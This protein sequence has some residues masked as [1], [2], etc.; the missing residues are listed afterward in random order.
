MF[1]WRSWWRLNTKYVWI[2]LMAW[3]SRW[4]GIEAQEKLLSATYSSF[5]RRIVYYWERRAIESVRSCNSRA[6]LR[7]LLATILDFHALG[8]VSHVRWSLSLLGLVENNAHEPWTFCSPCLIIDIQVPPVY[9][10]HFTS[11]V[12]EFPAIRGEV[13][14]CDF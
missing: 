14:F 7:W 13:I 10:R 3:Q 8:V 6:G 2:A 1:D 12:E 11:S 5:G 9:S 4:S